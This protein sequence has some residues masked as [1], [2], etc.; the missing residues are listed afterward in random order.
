MGIY[1]LYIVCSLVNCFEGMKI[2]VFKIIEK[3]LLEYVVFLEGII[4]NL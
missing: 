4:I 1:I 3:G 2:Y